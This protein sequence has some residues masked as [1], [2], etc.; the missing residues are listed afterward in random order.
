MVLRGRGARRSSACALAGDLLVATNTDE[1]SSGAGGLALVLHGVR[2]GRRASSPSRRASTSGSPAAARATRRSPSPGVRATP[3]STSPTGARAA[4]STRSRRR[5]SCSTRSAACARSGRSAP[6]F[7]TPGSRM[8]DILPTLISAGEWAVTY[9]AECR[10]TIAVLCVPQQTDDGWLDVRRRARGRRVD[11]ERAAAADPWL[12][13][14]PPTIEWWPNRVMSLEI[15]ADEPIV[16]IMA[17]AT[18]DV[19]RPGRLSGLDSWYDGA[20]FTPP[21]RHA[22]DRVRAAGLRSRTDAASPTR[23][24]STSRSTVSST[25]AQGLAVAATRFC[26]RRPCVTLVVPELPGRRS[27]RSRS[28]S[29]R[30]VEDEVYPLEARDRRARLDRPG[31]DRTSCAGRRE[32]RA[33]RS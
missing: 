18:A 27:R 24:T 4:P 9:P 1:E 23:S 22:R 3:R 8:P 13:E 15:P 31:R 33:S 17:E 7:V 21:R 32:P 10:I 2:G 20:T 16:A 25:C 14:H 29:R 6:T 26:G 11:R 28:A 5:R 19:G 30:F 12:A